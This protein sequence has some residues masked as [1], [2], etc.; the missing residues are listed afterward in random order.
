MRF[1]T[2]TLG[3]KV[4]QYETGAIERILIERGHEL[5]APGDGCDV[6]IVNTCAVTAEG[7]R[8]SRAAIRRMKRLEPSAMIAVCGCY[9]ELD[10]ATVEKLDVDI[11]YGASDKGSF[12]SKI[13]STKIDFE[14]LPPGNTAS[15]TRA[16]LKIQDGCNN[17]CTYCIVPY[18]RGRSRSLPLEKVT[19][20]AKQLGEKG[21][22]EIVITGIEVSSY[23]HEEPDRLLAAICAVH[24]A[25]PNARLRLG[26]LQPSIMTGDFCKELS[27]IPN[28]CNHF[29]LSLQSGCDKTLKR[30][31]RK[32]TTEQVAANMKAIRKHFPGCGIT[33]DL[34]IGF[35]GET[36]D[37]FEQ[38]LSFVEKAEFSDMHVFPYSARPGTKAAEMEGQIEK[39]IKR[40]RSRMVTAVAKDKALEFKKTYLEKTVEVLFERD[41]KGFSIGHTTNY[42]EVAAKPQ[43]ERNTIKTVKI[44]AY[45]NGVLYGEII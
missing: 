30:M 38:T 21:Y 6:C 27:K 15:R 14:E 18:L 45:A 32:Y 24:A 5:V 16:Y 13:I 37:E 36:D 41:K 2:Q 19:E 4:N 7:D 11:L 3:C 20:Y 29:H 8:K 44:T 10:P 43:V 25:V 34:I 28:I 33:A 39:E 40:V 17:F 26:S 31:G 35:P 1:C 12:I 42:L 9:S 23:C 22:K